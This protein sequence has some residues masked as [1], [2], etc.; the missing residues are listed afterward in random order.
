MI[1]S[2]S[3]K[4]LAAIGFLTVTRDAQQGLF[5]GYLVLNYLGRPLEFHCTAPVRPNRAQAILYGPT[6]DPYLCGERIGPTLLEKSKAAP[7]VVFTDCEPAM[8]ARIF[9]ATPMGLVLD[10]TQPADPAGPATDRAPQGLASETLAPR[11]GL[12]FALLP[13]FSLGSVDVAVLAEHPED[14]PQLL[15][16]WTQFAGQIDLHEPFGRIRDAIDE[17][18]ASTR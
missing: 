3:Q 18:R 9:V 7:Q 5:G 8:A 10:T 13:R 2:A 12:G 15:E 6:L 17:A 16:C 4:S 11:A 14:Q 1:R